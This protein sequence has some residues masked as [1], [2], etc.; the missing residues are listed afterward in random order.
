MKKVL[1][2]GLFLMAVN[3]SFASDKCTAACHKS[4]H[5]C[6]A[7][8]HKNGKGHVAN[9]GEKEHTCTTKDCKHECTKE[10]MKKA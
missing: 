4:E 10:C 2:A 1:L 3:F 6:T 8:C 9:H 7:S 5:K